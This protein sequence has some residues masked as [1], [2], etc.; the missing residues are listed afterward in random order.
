MEGTTKALIQLL[1]ILFVFDI[2]RKIYFLPKEINNKDNNN[3]KIYNNNQLDKKSKK[4]LSIKKGNEDKDEDKD[5]EEK[6]NNENNNEKNKEIISENGK[7]SKNKKSLL[8]YYDKFLYDKKFFKLKDEIE[9][10]YTNIMVEGVEYPL[11]ESKKFFLKFSYIIQ[12]GLSLLIIF[13]KSLK[14]GLPFLSD[15]AIKIIE[16]YKWII[17]I[18]N[19]VIHFWLNK[20][21]KATGAFEIMHNNNLLYSKLEKHILPNESDLK[22]IIKNIFIKHKV[23]NDDED[24][25]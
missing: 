9:N 6:N 5:N 22:K 25:F 2:I 15:N 23:S 8:I 20:Y 19:F 10:N 1:L 16:E 18:S 24:D 21:L 11:P 17:I 7:K 12:I 14:L 4:E 13:T 3:S